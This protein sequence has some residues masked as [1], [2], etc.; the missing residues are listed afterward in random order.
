MVE[1]GLDGGMWAIYTPQHGRTPAD[2]RVARDHGLTRLLQIHQLLA[3]HPDQ[4]EL[5][6]T[7]EDAPRIAQAASAWCTSAWRMP[8]R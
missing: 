1:G 5:A 8:R 7:P 3:A 4:F 6:L 2:D